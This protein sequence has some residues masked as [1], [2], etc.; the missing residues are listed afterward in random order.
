MGMANGIEGPVSNKKIRL[1]PSFQTWK[2]TEKNYF[3]YWGATVK[4]KTEDRRL[5]N[6]R[7]QRGGGRWE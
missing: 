1:V 7:G 3:E 2:F 6:G 4:W 5:I